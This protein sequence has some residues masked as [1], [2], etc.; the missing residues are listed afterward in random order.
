M[1]SEPRMLIPTIPFDYLY[2]DHVSNGI[3]PWVLPQGGLLA[4][5]DKRIHREL[6]RRKGRKC[7]HPSPKKRQ[8][9]NFETIQP[10]IY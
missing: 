10:H 5:S 2:K 6:L 4:H 8:Q 1:V 7:C 3:D 9:E